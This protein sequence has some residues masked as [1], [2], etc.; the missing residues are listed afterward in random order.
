MLDGSPSLSLYLSLFQVV[1]DIKVV[2]FF[3]S[4]SP[5]IFYLGCCLKVLLC[6]AVCDCCCRL[7]W[8]TPRRADCLPRE[9]W[10]TSSCQREVMPI[11]YPS[12][13]HAMLQSQWSNKSPHPP[14]LTSSR[15]R[16]H[17]R[18]RSERSSSI[19]V[20]SFCWLWFRRLIR[21]VSTDWRRPAHTWP[22]IIDISDPV[23]NSNSAIRVGRNR[24]L[25]STS[26]SSGGWS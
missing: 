1:V 20:V 24:L 18:R 10:P 14:F 23:S 8:P 13:L 12:R 16:R 22:A 17:R 15:R 19:V 6:C 5:S 3:P 7:A 11:A 9:T 25:S 21:S 4:I 26:S 2:S